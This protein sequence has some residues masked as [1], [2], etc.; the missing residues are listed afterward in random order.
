MAGRGIDLDQEAIDKRN[1]VGE[2]GI[3][4]SI[5]SKKRRKGELDQVG[6]PMSG[7]SLSDPP[8][9]LRRSTGG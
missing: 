5:M 8:T 4:R 6:R 3:A 9:Y 2:L 7:L 1:E